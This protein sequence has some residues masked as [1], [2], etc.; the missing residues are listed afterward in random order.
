MTSQYMKEE[1][2]QA[3]TR[4]SARK[5]RLGTWQI[6]VNIRVAEQALKASAAAARSDLVCTRPNPNSAQ[7]ALRESFFFWES[8]FSSLKFY[9][10]NRN[11]FRNRLRKAAISYRSQWD[12]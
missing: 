5:T 6:K 2:Q 3:G 12:V 4:T 7:R 1:T 9:S 11:H 10:T 8:T